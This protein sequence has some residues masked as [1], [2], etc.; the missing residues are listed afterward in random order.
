MRRYIKT[1]CILLCLAFCLLVPTACGSKE[2]PTTTAAEIADSLK[3]LSSESITWVEISSNKLS[4]YF[5]FGPD[6]VDEFKGYINDSEDS[7]DIIAVFKSE[8]RQE[9]ITGINLLVAEQETTYKVASENVFAKINGKIIAEKDDFIVFCI[10]DS[11]DKASKYLTKT[12]EA[13]IIS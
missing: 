6:S 11:Y 5:G 3:A 7:Y 4:S 10:V 2:K 9:V 13:K 1:I 12:L 8:K